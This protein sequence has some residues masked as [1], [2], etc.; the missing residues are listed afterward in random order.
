MTGYVVPKREQSKS[1]GEGSQQRGEKRGN[2]ALR[3]VIK[4]E[5]GKRK[6]PL[7]PCPDLEASW[8]LISQK[9]R[10]KKTKK[11]LFGSRDQ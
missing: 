11:R 5:I 6:T 8:L 4:N 1:S 3:R 9:S 2:N 10:E 7:E